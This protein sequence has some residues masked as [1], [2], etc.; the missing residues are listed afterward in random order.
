MDLLVKVS[1]YNSTSLLLTFESGEQRVLDINRLFNFNDPHLSDAIK[2][3]WKTMYDEGEFFHYDI[4][5]GDLVF[6]GW[7]EIFAEDLKK[8]TVPLAIYQKLELENKIF[9]HYGS[10]HF[11]QS[12]FVEAKNWCGL[13]AKP[14]GG[15]WGSPVDSEKSWLKWCERNE[16]K[17]YLKE[18]CFYFRLVTAYNW[19]TIRSKEE[20]LKY[21]KRSDVAYEKYTILDFEKIMKTGIG[22]GI[23]FYAIA[24]EFEDEDEYEEC[25]P[26]YDC[27]S[28]IVLNDSILIENYDAK[29][30]EHPLKLTDL[31]P[32]YPFM[33]IRGNIQVCCLLRS[34]DEKAYIYFEEPDIH[35]GFKI[36][37]ACI[38]D[39]RIV[40]VGGYSEEEAYALIEEMKPFTSEIERIVHENRILLVQPQIGD[41]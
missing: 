39:G 25:F 32:V 18:E 24:T 27:D 21:P 33:E 12:R 3:R 28:I 31:K 11:D 22:D 13:N 5:D 1:P 4:L 41:V 30:M 16:Y 35:Y 37:V 2:L 23:P 10:N 38:T 9:V 7:V 36:L 40:E 17:S 15:L 8:Q 6:G 29:R 20:W 26:G 14:Y 34:P 19:T